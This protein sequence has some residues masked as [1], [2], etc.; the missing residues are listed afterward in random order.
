MRAREEAKQGTSLMVYLVVQGPCRGWLPG[1][2]VGYIRRPAQRIDACLERAASHL[3][4]QLSQQQVV[5]STWAQDAAVGCPRRLVG[6]PGKNATG[7]FL[8]P[9]SNL[10]RH[11]TTPACGCRFAHIGLLCQEIGAAL[12]IAASVVF[13]AAPAGFPLGHIP[14]IILASLQHV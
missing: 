2:S 6:G 5:V 13:P 8:F 11:D 4:L 1:V 12:S 7:L 14:P 10:L 9:R 3:L